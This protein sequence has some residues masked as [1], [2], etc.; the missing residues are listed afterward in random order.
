M[1]NKLKIHLT[2]IILIVLIFL[3]GSFISNP[4]QRATIYIS[5]FGFL[6]LLSILFVLFIPII[7]KLKKNSFTNSLIT[8]RRWIGIYTFVFALIHVFLVANLFFKF[9]ISK[10]VENPYRVLGL[11]A[12]VILVLMAMTSNDQSMKILKKNWKRLHFLIYPALILM[13]IHSFNLGLIFVKSLTVKIIVI[14]L[15]LII[16]IWKI[17]N[18]FVKDGKN[19]V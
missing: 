5:S 12:F 9:N 8:N 14:T 1:D 11:T 10:I 17:R 7:Y 6:A 4:Q 3:M 13:I 15:A 18:K 2:G 19:T 16:I